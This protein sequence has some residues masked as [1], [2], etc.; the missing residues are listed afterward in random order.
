MFLELSPEELN[1]LEVALKKVGKRAA[2]PVEQSRN[3]S[4]RLSSL[5]FLH[6]AQL[7]IVDSYFCLVERRGERVS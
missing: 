6:A 4:V 7:Y 1:G 2:V 5:I 3:V